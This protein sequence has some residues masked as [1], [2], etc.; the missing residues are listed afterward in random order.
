M[1]SIDPSLAFKTKSKVGYVVSGKEPRLGGQL[2]EKAVWVDEATCIGCRY[3]SNVASNTFVIEQTFGRS[4]AIR[5][6][7]DRTEI[8]QEAIDTCPVDCIHWVPFEELEQLRAKLA[9]L[10]FQSLG[11]LPKLS[12]RLKPRKS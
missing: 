10:D 2:R 6:D 9:A 3:C 5:Q 12:K 7:G 4:R 11:M 8:I 1:S